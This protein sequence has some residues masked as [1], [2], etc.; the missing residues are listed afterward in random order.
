MFILDADLHHFW[1]ILGCYDPSPNSP[2]RTPNR[3]VLAPWAQFQALAL[4]LLSLPA[5]SA[6]SSIWLLYWRSGAASRTSNTAYST[7]PLPASSLSVAIPP[8]WVSGWTREISNWGWLHN[9]QY[10]WFRVARALRYG[11]CWAGY[12][13][14]ASRGSRC[15]VWPISLCSTLTGRSPF[16]ST[17]YLTHVL[18]GI[19]ESWKSLRR[20][21]WKLCIPHLSDWVVPC[22]WL[23]TSPAR[24][25]VS[26]ASVS[27]RATTAQSL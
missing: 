2:I 8:C 1:A 16:L 11:T 20:L 12:S 14:W 3:T 6:L 25:T 13:A 9:R 18:L 27:W 23:S 19:C 5:C 10:F 24:S 15:T 22:C 7:R 4:E 21:M 26:R 17:F